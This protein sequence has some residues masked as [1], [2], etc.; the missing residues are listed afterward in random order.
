MDRKPEQNKEHIDTET[1][2]DMFELDK[3][4]EQGD[5][6]QIRRKDGFYNILVIG[7]DK[8]ALN[9]DVMI[10]ASIDTVNKTAATVQIPRDSYVEY[11][12]GQGSKINAVFADGYISARN[13]LN[14]LKKAASGKSDEEIKTLCEGSSLEIT[15]QTL[16]DFMSGK[17]KQDS[18]CTDYGIKTLQNMISCTFGIYFDYYAVVSTDAFV[19]IVDAIGGVDVYVQ[20]PMNYDDPYQ[21]LHIHIPAGNQHLDGKKAE[22]F[23]RFRAGY[24]QADIARL[25]AQKIFLTAFF[26]KL[27]SFSSVTRVG[28]ILSAVYDTVKTDLTLDNAIGFIKPALSIDLSNITMLTMQG[29]PYRNGMYYSLDK[30]QNLKIV[31]DHFNIFNHPLS[32]VAINV[33]ELV[34]PQ[35][36]EQESGM[37]MGDIST[38]QPDLNFVQ[39]KP[40]TQTQTQ[41]QPSDPDDSEESGKTEDADN[42]D[43]TDPEK[44]DGKESGEKDT[45]DKTTEN[46]DP[47]GNTED[48]EISG[49]KTENNPDI[50]GETEKDR[51]ES[52]ETSDEKADSEKSGGEKQDNTSD[53]SKDS[54]QKD[55]K[56][57]EY[58][59]TDFEESPDPSEDA[60]Q[61]NM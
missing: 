54:E 21:D 13:E 10:I 24:V 61:E 2:K 57:N 48:G 36:Q 30:A 4:Q 14:R 23:V 22:G 37:T 33:V 45:P 40:Q 16:S 8:V 39:R 28:D 1:N 42:T 31:N 17:T 52:S 58:N 26:K 32:E 35:Q 46:K 7:R 53:E 50:T 20:E 11:E 60:T 5:K 15:P 41:H 56:D 51:E 38:K 49:E 55:I 3:E 43:N 44:T 19:K 12:N 34:K 25:D 59:V 47:D 27:V 29:T 6:N 18:L 9:T